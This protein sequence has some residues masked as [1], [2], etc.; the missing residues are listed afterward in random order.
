MYIQSKIGIKPKIEKLVKT[1]CNKGF[2]K[3]TNFSA[4]SS[5]ISTPSKRLVISFWAAKT[6]ALFLKA[7]K[8]KT[9]EDISEDICLLKTFVKIDPNPKIAVPP[10]P[11]ESTILVKRFNAYVP[12][13]M[14][15]LKLSPLAKA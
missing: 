13:S 1:I 12:K 4:K 15:P 2:F 10:P 3:S 6:E 14:N 7:S 8:F 9:K 11:I 5:L